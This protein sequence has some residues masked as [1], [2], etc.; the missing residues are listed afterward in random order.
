MRSLCLTLLL[1]LAGSSAMAQYPYYNPYYNYSYP[2]RMDWQLRQDFNNAIRT[3][4]P[5]VYQP[6]VTNYPPPL[7]LPQAYTRGY[8]TDERYKMQVK[9]AFAIGGM[10]SPFEKHERP[11]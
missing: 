7:T 10:G 2:R 6:R 11:R 3:P 9:A 5:Q 1:S 4:A 8:V